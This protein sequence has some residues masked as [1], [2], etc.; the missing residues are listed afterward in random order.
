[1]LTAIA[2]NLL[3]VFLKYD[4]CSFHRQILHLGGT[5]HKRGLKG[6][7]AQGT[8]K[9]GSSGASHWKCSISFSS[10][11]EFGCS[12]RLASIAAAP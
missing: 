2:L 9:A 12:V 1:M 6:R 8:C 7:M 10:N 4:T 11:D 3:Q 5:S